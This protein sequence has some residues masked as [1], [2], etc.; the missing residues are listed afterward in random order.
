ML[1][2]QQADTLEESKV[3]QKQKQFSASFI[4]NN[5]IENNMLFANETNYA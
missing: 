1:E 5:E 4:P 2:L 3:F